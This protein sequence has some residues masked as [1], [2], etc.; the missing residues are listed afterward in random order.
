MSESARRAS[1]VLPPRARLPAAA[2][3]VAWLVLAGRLVQLQWAE[4]ADLSAGAIRQSSLLDEIP[5]RPGEILDRHGRL[6]A[7]TVTTRSLYLVPSR[8]DDGWETARRLGEALDLDADDLFRRLGRDRERHFLWVRRRLS[9]AEAERVKALD[10]PQGTWGFR[11]EHLRRYP[12]GTLAAHVLGLRDID[13]AGRGGI[14]QSCDAILRGTPGRCVLRRDARGRVLD[15]RDE[16]AQPP[17]PGRTVTLALDAVVQMHAERELDRVMEEWRPSSAAAIVLGVP[18]CDVLAMASRPAFDPNDASGVPAAAWKNTAIASIHEPGSTFKPFVV[19][20]AI[21]Q[22]ALARDE[23]F[24][25]EHGAYRMGRRVLHDHHPYGILD[26]TG[27]LVKSSNIGMAKIGARLG[28]RGLHQAAAAFGF[29]R[30]TGIELPGEL[31][32]ILR[33]LDEWTGYSTGSIPMG[34]ELA[35]TPLQVAVAHA[36]LASKGTH[37]TPRLVLGAG[38]GAPFAQ[39]SSAHGERQSNAVVS[40]VLRPEIAEWLVSGPLREVVTRGTGRRAELEEYTVFGKS[41]T[42]QK[43]DPETGKYSMRLHTSSFVCG[44]PAADPRA[45]VLVV[46]DEPSRGD[47][48]FG[49]TIAAPAASRIL[50]K[51]L[52]ALRV[53]ARP[54]QSNSPPLRAAER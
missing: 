43:L 35:A 23:R 8:T 27:I 41:G 19:G 39:E 36:A 3:V 5:A 31:A 45:I 46:V 18:E 37:R 34:Q 1:F 52:L 42:A 38:D 24:D 15:V 40:R 17:R 32:G 30:P 25:C 29:G 28:N 16:V 33:P 22:G 49:G 44:G 9:D 48:Q 13:G 14:E 6:L 54:P 21:E 2:V 7:T 20:W 10:L 50:R 53:P 47:S 11:E 4:Q 26:V 12:Q 51:T